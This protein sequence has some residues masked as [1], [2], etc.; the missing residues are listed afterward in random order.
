MQVK[1]YRW[2][3]ILLCALHNIDGNFGYKFGYRHQFALITANSA[4][5]RSRLDLANRNY[6]QLRLFIINLRYS[7]ETQNSQTLAVVG[8]RPPLPAPQ[9]NYFHRLTA[10][11]GRLSRPIIRYKHGYGAH[12]FY[13]YTLKPIP[14]LRPLRSICPS[15]TLYTAN[16]GMRS[17]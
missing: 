17:G 8:V 1:F 4:K 10:I 15:L 11:S 12:L 16:Y 9:T 7:W 13:F 3:R 5:L 2:R 14:R 6:A